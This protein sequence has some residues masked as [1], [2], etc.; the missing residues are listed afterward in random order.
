MKVQLAA[1]S[2]RHF[3]CV[4]GSLCVVLPPEL[5]QLPSL[6]LFPLA[7]AQLSSGLRSDGLDEGG[8]SRLPSGPAQLVTGPLAV[9]VPACPARIRAALGVCPAGMNLPLPAPPCPRARARAH[10]S[11]WKGSPDCSGFGITPP[12]PALSLWGAQRQHP[13]KQLGPSQGLRPHQSHGPCTHSGQPRL[14]RICCSPRVINTPGP[15]A[16][17]CCR[18]HWEQTPSGSASGTEPG[19]LGTEN[20]SLHCWS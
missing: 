11:H 20:R 14:T 1:V 19:T 5:C 8:R 7:G 4:W 3:P 10:W 17:R 13:A 12:S 6:F 15:L 16:Q 18:V 2:P 9:A